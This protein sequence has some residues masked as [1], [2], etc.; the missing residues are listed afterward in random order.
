MDENEIKNIYGNVSL[1]SAPIDVENPDYNSLLGAMEAVYNQ[2]EPM[3]VLIRY[4]EVLN[5]RN[6]EGKHSLAM[7]LAQ[8]PTNSELRITMSTLDI[9]SVML[10]AVKKY[11]EEPT[12]ENMGEAVNLLLI[13]MD[14]VNKVNEFLN[15]LEQGV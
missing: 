5:A 4:Y 1:N 9:L 2:R 12:L 3:D 7:I 14:K 6:E 15:T 11:T 8:D 10:G 13:S